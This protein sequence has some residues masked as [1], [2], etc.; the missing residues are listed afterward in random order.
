[1]SGNATIDTKPPLLFLHDVRPRTRR[2]PTIPHEN[3]TQQINPGFNFPNHGF[4]FPGH[5]AMPQMPLFVYPG[6]NVQS[7]QNS[8]SFLPAAAYGAAAP[9]VPVG[10]LGTA[11]RPIKYPSLIDWFASLDTNEERNKDGIVFAPYGAVLKDK[12]FLRLS[13]LS[14]ELFTL[15]DLEEWLGISVGTAVLIMQYA[16]EDIDNLKACHNVAI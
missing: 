2:G 11:Q 15:K 1:M 9:A 14:L 5:F 7:V 13:Q 16:K 3:N 6:H 10:S 4:N 12:G 8:M